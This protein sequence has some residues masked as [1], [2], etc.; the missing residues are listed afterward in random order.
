MAAFDREGT[1]KKAEKALRQG[2]IDVAIDEY[3]RIIDKHPRDWN[4]ANALGDLYVRANQIENGVTQYTRIAD[5]LAEEGF[6]PKA[7]AVYKKILKIKPDHDHAAL[8]SAEMAA[9]QGLT[10]D[11][12]TFLH[13]AAERR[14]ARGDTRGAAE[15]TIRIGAL[16]PE[17]LDAR[18]SAAR[19][20]A[21]TG[22]KAA[23]LREYTAVGVEYDQQGRPDE[24]LGAFQLAFEL[25]SQDPELRRRL[26]SGYL[27]SGLLARARAIADSVAE[28]RE[29]AAALDEAGRGED[30]LD[31]LAAI[32]QKDPH[33][34]ATRA[35]LTRALV[36]KG[37]LEKARAFL[38]PKTAGQDAGLWLTLAE[39]EL[40]AGRMTEGRDAAAQVIRLDPSSRDAV[41]DLAWRLTEQSPDAGYLCVDAV[42]DAARAER[43]YAAAVA[44]L[45]P[46]V[47]RVPSHIVAL[48]RLVDVCVDGGLDRAM[49]EAQAQLA[50]AY[51]EVGRGLEA[52]II[53]EDLVAV[54][55][56]NRAN[57]DRFRRALVMTG[58]SDPDKVINERVS[59]E[60][61][62]FSTD[63][64]DLNEFEELNDAG[65]SDV[66]SE[67]PEVASADSGESSMEAPMATV[68][69]SDAWQSTSESESLESSEES[70]DDAAQAVLEQRAAEQYRLAL[71]YRELGMYDDSVQALEEAARSPRQRFDACSLLGRIYQE[72]EETALAV[73]WLE[74]AAESPPPTRDAGRALLYDL[75][76][77]LD[78]LGEPS[79]ALA[80]FVELESESRGYRDVS[81]R[82]ERLSKV[83]IKG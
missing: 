59:G 8:Q 9:K 35:R 21:E 4:S 80:V 52:R 6:Y 66:S 43:D 77:A 69:S 61:P 75:G 58:E 41:L 40:S 64:L 42:V 57:L 26:L 68:E 36:N 62:F 14:R 56:A 53:S 82:I 27:Q 78:E 16:D 7:A 63:V 51:L 49:Y 74:R 12:K 73:M 46:F 20:A 72:R 55:S 79:R 32:A 3:R 39:I 81:D 34:A 23:A 76:Q 70:H 60:S 28:L 13:A 37:E 11:A 10:L 48:M 18:L 22:D 38:T 1:L 2:R 15:I 65:E 31:V 33:D 29:L 44:A 83:Q 30:L 25:N 67:A 19:A 17:D 54:D 71:T 45:E 24:A 50:D 47:I 5:H